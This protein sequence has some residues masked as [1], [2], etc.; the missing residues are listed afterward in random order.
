MFIVFFMFYL[1]VYFSENPSRPS[2]SDSLQRL[3]RK[4]E[5][6]NVFTST[7][8]P[9][10]IPAK[11]MKI[12]QDDSI[13][14]DGTKSKLSIGLNTDESHSQIL[15]PKQMMNQLKLPR[16]KEV[17]Q[18][19]GV[20]QLLRIATKLTKLDLKDILSE[21]KYD[22]VS[23]DLSDVYTRLEK[24]KRN[25]NSKII[26]TGKKILKMCITM[27]KMDIGPNDSTVSANNDKLTTRIVRN[28]LKSQLRSP[29]TVSKCRIMLVKKHSFQLGK[30][31]VP[32]PASK[33]QSVAMMLAQYKKLLKQG[34]LSTKEL[35]DQIENEVLLAIKASDLFMKENSKKALH[36]PKS[37][38]DKKSK[39]QDMS[40][41]NDTSGKIHGNHKKMQNQVKRK[42]VKRS[43]LP[44]MSESSDIFVKIPGLQD[45]P[46]SK[47]VKKLSDML[48]S[49]NASGNPQQSQGHPKKRK[50]KISKSHN[51]SKSSNTSVKM[52]G[53][54]DQ[55]KKKKVKK[56]KLP[57]MSDSINTYMP[58]NPPKPQSQPK[59]RKGKKSKPQHMADTSNTSVKRQG[60]Q[61]QPKRKKVK[62]SK[63]PDMLDSINASGNSPKSQGQPKKRKSKK[64]KSQQMAESSNTSIKMQG[65]Q[66]H[67]KRKKIKKSKLP[68]MSNSI[69]ASGNL[70]KSQGQP[71]KRKG[72]K[73]KSSNTSDKMDGLQDQPKRKKTEKPTFPH[74][75]ESS[76]SSAKTHGNPQKSQ[77]Q[78]KRK[79]R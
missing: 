64:S 15:T 54:Q 55:P 44:H 6:A 63:L 72:K 34:K 13:H 40:K 41:F 26:E 4:D 16:L 30:V 61:S 33:A 11:R 8:K 50:S 1:I 37:K 76:D 79:K 32:L 18:S 25:K 60:L 28:H 70:Q 52:E 58:G 42:K 17:T 48:D 75:S 9:G 78:P 56:S 23:K 43:T 10:H 77:G 45:Q 71:K 46:T 2:L 19:S 53:V 31:Y 3:D 35:K 36:L 59:K 5:N 29:A 69:N 20:A 73:S 14:M 51:M 49:I 74:M 7:P 68:D 12:P 57:D 66:D 27:I 39:L 22:I 21:E 47:K 62:K 65:L 67:P 24:A 38:R